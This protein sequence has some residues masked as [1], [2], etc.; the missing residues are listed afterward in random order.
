MPA[1][2]RRTLRTVLSALLLVV[3]ALLALAVDRGAPD[4]GSAGYS[5][6]LFDEPNFSVRFGRN[7]LHIAGT[8]ASPVHEAALLQLVGEQ[9][10][11]PAI[12]TDFKAAVIVAEDWE[13]LSTRLLYL[14]AATE[15]ANASFDADSISIRG[16]TRHA[17]N[18]QNRL[19]FLER[20]MPEGR[21]VNSDVLVVS[22]SIPFDGL[23]RRNF[24]SL[25]NESIRFRHSSTSIRQSSYPLLDKLVEF[26]YDCRAQKI[27]ITGHTDATGST[28]WN[29]QISRARA[30]AVADHMIQRG[31][32]RE[33]LIVDGRGSSQPIADNDT[34]Q[35]REQNRRIEIELR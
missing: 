19:A 15:T 29:Q 14:V 9:F 30:E 10:K 11:D 18:Y 6:T 25:T 1:E 27:A 2:R 17:S 16:I 3:G 35:G 7:H 20:V 24:A 13:V 8:T 21:S 23:C 32:L 22:N 26:A 33:R 34:V 4:E 31:V 12:T 28:A 5:P